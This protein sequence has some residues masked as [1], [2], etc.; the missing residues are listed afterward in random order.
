MWFCFHL[1]AKARELSDTEDAKAVSCLWNFFSSSFFLSH[2]RPAVH[3][4][5]R[6]LWYLKCR[7]IRKRTSDLGRSALLESTLFWVHRGTHNA[8]WITSALAA[9]VWVDDKSGKDTPDLTSQTFLSER[10]LQT[11]GS[12]QPIIRAASANQI[13]T[14]D[15][16]RGKPEGW[17]PF[18]P[19]KLKA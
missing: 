3:L 6:G 7:R 10:C 2:F 1:S 15:I 17:P 16:L 4:L 19:Y 11:E 18:L 14:N 9:I 5:I 13:V 8:G 12:W